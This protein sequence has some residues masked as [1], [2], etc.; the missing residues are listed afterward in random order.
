MS[1]FKCKILL[2]ITCKSMFVWLL[3]VLC[4]VAAASAAITSATTIHY[5]CLPIYKFVFFFLLLSYRYIDIRFYYYCC[6]YCCC[7]FSLLAFRLFDCLCI[8]FIHYMYIYIYL[9]VC[10]I[11][12]CFFVVRK[13]LV[14][15]IYI[16]LSTMVFIDDDDQMVC[17]FFSKV[18]TYIG[19]WHIYTL[20]RC[21]SS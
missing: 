1:S 15:N 17:V 5:R 18:H 12:I 11:A 7:F 9:Y 10:Y 19:T 3:A 21:R 6:C 2:F 20:A 16:L 8:H 13:R 14:D 4:C